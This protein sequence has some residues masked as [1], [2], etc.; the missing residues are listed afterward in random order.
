LA[1]QKIIEITANRKG[2]RKQSGF[3]SWGA[4]AASLLSSAALPTIPNAMQG[5]L[6]MNVRRAF[7]QAA[8]KDR[9]AACA[10]RKDSALGLSTRGVVRF[11]LG[12]TRRLETE[13]R[14]AFFHQIETI[15][16]NRFQIG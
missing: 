16:R 3:R 12:S 11:R 7:R 5:F 2:V 4:Q 9:L 13:N 6:A 14:F 10:R 8:E 15:A 1:L